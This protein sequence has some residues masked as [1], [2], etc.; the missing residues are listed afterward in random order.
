MCIMEGQPRK[1][2]VLCK[3]MSLGFTIK[4]DKNVDRGYTKYNKSAPLALMPYAIHG[5]DKNIFRIINHTPRT[6]N[7]R[8]GIFKDHLQQD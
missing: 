5:R 6:L 2:H 7:I 1:G 8:S 3:D 4:K